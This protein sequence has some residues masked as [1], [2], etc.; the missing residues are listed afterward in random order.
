MVWLPHPHSRLQGPAACGHSRLR[1]IA[2]CHTSFHRLFGPGRPHSYRIYIWQVSLVGLQYSGQFYDI[3]GGATGASRYDPYTAGGASWLPWW[4]VFGEF[5]PAQYNGL[6]SC[7]VWLYIFTSSIVLVNL[8][9][10]LFSDTVARVKNDSEVEYV[11]WRARRNFE[12]RHMATAV[13]P[14]LNTPILF[15]GLLTEF[16]VQGIKKVWQIRH[17]GSSFRDG[18]KFKK[19]LATSVRRA[20]GSAVRCAEQMCHRGSSLRR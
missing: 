8:L 12:L 7:M 20:E 3:D 16:G 10:A 18:N 4:A 15:Y 6:V 11:Y 9:I 13:P 5:N 17:I 14:V 1:P 19:A 2:R